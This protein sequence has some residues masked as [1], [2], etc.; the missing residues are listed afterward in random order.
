MKRVINAVKE[1]EIKVL[2]ID[3]DVISH[4]LELFGAH[5]S[6][7][8]LTNIEWYD[9]GDL[10][11]HDALFTRNI[12]EDVR[13]F[14]IAKNSKSLCDA[15]GYLRLRSQAAH[16]LTFKYM[17]GASPRISVSP[18]IEHEVVVPIHKV[19]LVRR[20]LQSAGFYMKALHQKKRISYRYKKI[21]FDIDIWPKIPPYLEIEAREERY[22]TAAL[23]ALQLSDYSVSQ[24]HG[25]ALFEFYGVNFWSNL[26]F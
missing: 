15:G 14:M 2:D 22:V 25:P 19:P 17:S 21:S 10:P 7:S 8:G 4:K 23:N 6:F 24:R 26:Q 16:D 3:P 11:G 5:L 12:V 20:E 9:I 1:Y 18:F 13:L